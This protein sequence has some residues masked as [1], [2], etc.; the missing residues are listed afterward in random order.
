MTEQALA[1]HLAKLPHDLISS[2]SITDL[3]HMARRTLGRSTTLATT[4]PRA[5]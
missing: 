1:A 3:R 4:M 5:S 2:P